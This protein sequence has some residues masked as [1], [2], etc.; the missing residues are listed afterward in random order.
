VLVVTELVVVV[1]VVVVVAVK[2]GVL[3][4]EDVK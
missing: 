2:D 3:A 1:V 4:D